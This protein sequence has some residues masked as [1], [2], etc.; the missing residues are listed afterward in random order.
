MVC[1]APAPRNRPNP[2]G[3]HRVTVLSISRLRVLV[4]NLEALDGTPII[5]VK[6]LLGGIEER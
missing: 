6:P 4:R 5:D 2:V 1:S 3:L